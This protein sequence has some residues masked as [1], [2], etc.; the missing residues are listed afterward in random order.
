MKI[1][2]FCCYSV[3]LREKKNRIESARYNASIDIDE[4]VDTI[5][6]FPITDGYNEIAPWKLFEP[7][8]V[9]FNRP[10]SGLGRTD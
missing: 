6:R 9:Q 10:Q 4:S 1:S 7:V 5:V 8:A 3:K 2:K